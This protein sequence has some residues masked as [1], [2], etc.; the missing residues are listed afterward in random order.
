GGQ[1]TIEQFRKLSR[2][3]QLDII[4]YL[5]ELMPYD[6]FKING[7]IYLLVHSGFEPFDPTK[8]YS[9]YELHEMLFR[10]P[11]YNK[12][13]FSDKILVTGHTPTGGTIL[14]QNN[15]IAMDCGCVFGGKLGVLCLDTGQ[16]YYI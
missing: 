10:S 5:E 16:E 14:R 3:E 1:V 2:D 9:E 11:D 7:Q 12:V 13:Y 8:H 4:D 15:H 6:I